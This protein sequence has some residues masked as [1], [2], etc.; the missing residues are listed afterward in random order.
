MNDDFT[1]LRETMDQLSA[2]GGNADLHDRMLTTSRR[3]T[4]RNRIVASAAVAVA[5]VA[6][7]TPFTLVA[8][9]DSA[10]GPVVATQPS[11]ATTSPSPAPS[12]GEPLTPHHHTM[13]PASPAGGCPVT[14]QQLIDTVK[15]YDSRWYQPGD[16]WRDLECHDGW[17]S[18]WYVQKVKNSDPGATVFKY[19]TATRKWVVIGSGSGDYCTSYLPRGEW[20][21]FR[22]A[23]N[24]VDPAQPCP[25]GNTET[26]DA[27]EAG[28]YAD[29]V[30]SDDVVQELACGGKYA[31]QRLIDGAKTTFIMQWNP[32]Q[33][34]WHPIAAGPCRTVVRSPYADPSVCG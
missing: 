34:R 1:V 12:S 18:A 10:P 20:S 23:C 11:V 14:Q 5:V 13:V 9:R 4:R 22:I 33:H 6:I 19:D 27:I 3:I 17:A 28:Q 2:H 25:T 24:G 30:A 29:K 26:I 15:A 32:A 31:V 7:A 21:K 8:T 16:K